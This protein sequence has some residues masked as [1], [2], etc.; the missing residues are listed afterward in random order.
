MPA[1]SPSERCVR[2][3]IFKSA[4]KKIWFT[5]P[6]GHRGDKAT[7]QFVVPRASHLSWPESV[8]QEVKRDI[9]VLPFKLTILTI[10]AF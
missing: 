5:A 1:T 4:P 6:R 9:R 8:S 7:E 3:R 10:D 2:C